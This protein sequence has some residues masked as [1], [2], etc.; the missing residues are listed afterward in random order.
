MSVRLIPGP[1][2]VAWVRPGCNR[3]VQAMRDAGAVVIDPVEIPS[4]DD[5]FAD[6]AEMIVLV[7]EFKRDL[8]RYLVTCTGV[9]VGTVA[10]VIR[11]NLDHADEELQ[12]FGQEW[13]ELA[14]AEIF[15][16]AEYLAALKRGPML[17]ADLGIDAAL[18]E[19]NVDALVAP[20]GSP[21]WPTDLITGDCF[22]FGSSSFAAVAGY[23]L[24][25]V[26]GRLRV[27][28]AGTWT[29]MA[30]SL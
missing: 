14:E 1:K 12:F 15:S 5:F 9:P 17:A 8:N 10:D 16:E 6:P 18:V 26:P 3:A 4:F 7:F 29:S 28:S 22:Q 2:P 21:A 25:T 24:I 30:V 13:F 11:F 19:H 27:R 20:T 23:P